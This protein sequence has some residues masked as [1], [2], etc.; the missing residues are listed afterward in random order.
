[1]CKKVLVVEDSKN[2]LLMVRMCLEKHEYKVISVS[3]GIEAIDTVF[4]THPDL[5]LLDVLIPRMNGYL[6]AEALKQDDSTKNIPIIMMSARA[7]MD[8]IKKALELGVEDYLVKP[9][10]PDELI[11]KIKQY[12]N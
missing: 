4:Q 1:M 7:Q 11:K 10:S 8:D 2:I 5:I 12:T 3:D 9:F 6:V